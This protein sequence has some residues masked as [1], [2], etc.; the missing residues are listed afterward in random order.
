MGDRKNPGRARALRVGP[1]KPWGAPEIEPYSC[2]IRS[3]RYD[4]AFAIYARRSEVRSIGAVS[5]LRER[6]EV[7]VELLDHDVNADVRAIMESVALGVKRLREI[8]EHKWREKR[9]A[10]ALSAGKGE[11]RKNGE[12]RK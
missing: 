10:E 12:G 5:E 2:E 7:A 9:K 11:K 6:R 3:S 1:W 4:T 8:A